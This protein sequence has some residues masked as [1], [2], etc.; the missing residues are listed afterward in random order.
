[1]PDMY[2]DVDAAIT[3]CPVNLMPLIDDTDFKTRETAIAYNAAGMDLVWNFVTSAG[4]LTQTAVTPTT[5]GNYDWTHQGD[6]I[7]TIEIPAS[8]GASIN[9]DTEGYG[10]FSGLVTGVLPFRGPVIGFRAAALNDAL[11]D[12]G[13]NLDVNTV[14]WLGTACATPTVAGVPEVDLTHVAGATTNVSA[15]AT[16]VD[17]ILTDTATLPTASA[18][19]IGGLL[20][21]P[22]VANIGANA[23][24]YELGAV[25]F[26]TGGAAGAVSYTN[27]IV[28][29]PCSSPTNTKTLLTNLNLKV[30]RVVNA[31]SYTAEATYTGYSFIGEKW[32]LAP[33][34]QSMVNCYFKGATI[35]SGTFNASSTGC[36]FDQ[37]H[38]NTITI[39]AGATAASAT[40]FYQCGLNGTV[41]VGA[42]GIFNFANCFDEVAAGGEFTVDF[43]AV[44]ATTV[45]MDSFTGFL[46]V[47]N[48]AAGDVL[49]MS[50]HGRL[51]IAAS[52]TAGTI[53][54]S[55]NIVLV[56]NGSGQTINDSSRWNEDQRMANV[57]LVDT[58]T[59]YTGNTVQ[60][61]DSFARIGATGSGLTT[62]ATQAS[63]NTIDDFLDTEIAAILADTDAM[64][65][66]GVSVAVGG[67]AT[68]SF[69]AGAIDAA[70]VAADTGNELA[71]ALLNR[72]MATGTDSG[73]DSTAVRT[74]RQALRAIRNKVTVAAGVATI[75]KED[76]TT[77]SW[78]TAIGTTAGNP[79]SSSDPT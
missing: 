1:M 37:C 58:L 39:P 40:T 7:Y 68:T 14:Q 16:N 76:D 72:N 26:D 42:A 11:C 53:Y 43:A 45:H 13:D 32:T 23:S 62:L 79:I 17:A 33:A 69:A 55:G 71:D 61:G 29:N 74:P 27:G 20:T 63:V 19:A 9:N 2:F 38:I 56:N 60:T 5:A 64:T 3:E 18:G 25:W 6:G 52:C 21:A 67:I 24:G 48:M 22:T 34:A 70:S 46:T 47:A 57:T 30:I 4:A 66:A 51:T 59:T 12:G 50:G 49:E 54:I 8:G 31:S 73:T 77:A 15:L 75:T 78:T 41:T 35:T 36:Q 65:T 28:H 44:G 10:W